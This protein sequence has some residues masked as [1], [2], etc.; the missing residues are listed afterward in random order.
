MRASAFPQPRKAD[1]FDNSIVGNIR[2]VEC[3][4]EFIATVLS[5]HMHANLSGC[6]QILAAQRRSGTANQTRGR[7]LETNKHLSADWNSVLKYLNEFP[8]YW[9]GRKNTLQ[10]F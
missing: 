9:T 3:T 6:L 10:L 2:D 7:G 4:I 5:C 8:R 1:Q